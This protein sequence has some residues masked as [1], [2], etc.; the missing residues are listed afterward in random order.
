MTAQLKPLPKVA[1]PV[2]DAWI[3]ALNPAIASS[4]QAAMPTLGPLLAA[5]P[6]LLEQAMRHADWLAGALDAGPDAGRAALLDRSA[7][8]GCGLRGQRAS[9]G[10]VVA[11][12]RACPREH[13]PQ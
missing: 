6:Y 4:L 5:A 12:L 2:V 13:R 9:S 10:R 8:K 3:A 7:A 1:H 11:I